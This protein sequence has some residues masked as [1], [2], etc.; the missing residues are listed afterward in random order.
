MAIDEWAA[1]HPPS[2]RG[3][4]L[5]AVKCIRFLLDQQDDELADF[6]RKFFRTR[7]TIDLAWVRDLRQMI[8][9]VRRMDPGVMK[10]TDGSEFPR[11]HDYAVSLLESILVGA[12]K[13]RLV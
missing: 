13:P 11:T 4:D 8:D 9:L 1:A 6:L 10:Y 12:S 3:I 5:K 2:Q 7:R